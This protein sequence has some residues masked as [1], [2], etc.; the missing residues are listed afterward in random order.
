M[1]RLAILSDIHGNYDAL[2]QVLKDAEALRVDQIVC[3]GDCVGY[4]PE[5]EQVISEVRNRDLAT[6][7]GNHELALLDKKQLSW[8]N[9]M[10]GESLRK[11]RKMLSAES[12]DFILRL[13]SSLIVAGARCVHGY[14]PD[15]ARTYLF[16]KSIQTLRE[17]FN[18]LEERICFIGHTHDLALVR[19]NGKL[20]ERLP[21]D[22]GIAELDP[23]HKYIINI[24]SVGQP[25][26]G[27]NN[28]KYVIW[29]P[30]ANRIEVRFVPYDIASVVAKIEAAG[31]PE[32][33]G[34]RLW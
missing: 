19:F 18:T 30:D 8:F 5:P 17:T 4:G 27:N 26:D 32:V 23:D 28:A 6:V 2:I 21:L 22:C 34:R 25:R 31:L 12:L 7:M 10:A 11:T 9:P 16:Q 14:P 3:L 33:H 29:E 13:P 15:S 20:V 1:M 24:G